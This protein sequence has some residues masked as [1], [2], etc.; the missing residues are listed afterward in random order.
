MRGRLVSG[1]PSSKATCCVTPP[2]ISLVTSWALLRPRASA[3]AVCTTLRLSH[4][5]HCTLSF[6]REQSQQLAGTP[7]W[8]SAHAW[9]LCGPAAHQILSGH[10][11]QARL[12]KRAAAFSYVAAGAHGA[13]CCKPCMLTWMLNTA[14]GP[15]SQRRAISMPALTS[16]PCTQS[17]ASGTSDTS[18]AWLLEQGAVVLR[19]TASC[20]QHLALLL[21][22]HTQVRL[23]EAHWVV[24]QVQNEALSAI[25]L[26]QQGFSHL[27]DSS[28]AKASSGV[29]SQAFR[30]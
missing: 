26:L 18:T 27:L 19:C 24:A 8:P 20:R 10:A 15:R 11:L 4:C 3:N 13:S 5:T 9:G 1:T 25:I 2:H 21:T 22:G 29:N 30:C 28:N 12:L 16:P 14:L 23:E 7:A 6:G 17:C